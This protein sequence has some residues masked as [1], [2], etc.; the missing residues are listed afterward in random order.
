MPSSPAEPVR[1]RFSGL[2]ERS[3]SF[4]AGL[5]AFF[6][7]DELLSFEL[8]LPE[9]SYDR[10]PG[11]LV[12]ISPKPGAAVPSSWQS[13]LDA[14]NLTW[15]AP[16]DAGNEVH[17]ARRVGMALLAP[18]VAAAASGHEP[19]RRYLSGFSGGG[20]VAS[21]MMPTYP[22]AFSGALFIC[23]ANP[24]MVHVEAVTRAL[25]EVPMVFLTGTEDFNLQDTQLSFSTFKSTGLNAVTLSIIRDL[26]HALPDAED[27]NHALTQ[28]QSAP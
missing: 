25:A 2:V 23:G 11:V 19:E 21:M 5:A 3:A 27:L 15:V 22:A 24:L 6:E 17:V 9:N 7:P 13:V 28:L 14:H 1:E 20:R 12:Y 26:G 8:R 18:T 4:D 16:R 10:P